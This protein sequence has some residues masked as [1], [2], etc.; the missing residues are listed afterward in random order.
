MSCC[1]KTVK[2]PSS[3]TNK[4]SHTFL[5]CMTTSFR[6]N[7][8]ETTTYNQFV[9]TRTGNALYHFRFIYDL[10]LM[11]VCVWER[12]NHQPI[13][14]NKSPTVL[15]SRA[16]LC[17]LCK[18]RSKATKHFLFSKFVIICFLNI[19]MKLDF[20]SYSKI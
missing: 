20:F 17:G 11:Y 6:A 18:L 10:M 1:N 7:E 5:G 14:I 3:H 19:K 9:T 8:V 15:I 12:E 16:H 2:T 4:H 13:D